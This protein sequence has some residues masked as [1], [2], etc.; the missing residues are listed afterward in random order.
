MHEYLEARLELPRERIGIRL[1]AKNRQLLFA[2]DILR[3]C[4]FAV[5]EQYF[6]DSGC[7]KP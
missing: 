5:A 1:L 2:A 3:T 7:K 4:F 6:P